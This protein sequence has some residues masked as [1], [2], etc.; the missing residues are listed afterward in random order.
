MMG[1]SSPLPRELT[2]RSLFKSNHQHIA[3]GASLPQLR[4]VA[5]VQQVEH[6]VC[7]GDALARCSPMLKLTAYLSRETGHF[8]RHLSLSSSARMLARPGGRRPGCP[9]RLPSQAASNTFSPAAMPGRLLPA[10][11]RQPLHIEHL[12]LAP[13][14]VFVHALLRTCIPLAPA[15]MM[16]ECT[17]EASRTALQSPCISSGASASSRP[18][19]RRASPRFG[20]IRSRAGKHGRVA[21]FRVHQNRHAGA[22]ADRDDM[23]S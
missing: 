13:L 11:N 21:G 17:L 9:P 15:V 6:P 23:E 8:Q 14:Q 3:Q 1:R 12:P 22:I 2:E 10:W 18:A 20:L 16:T 5:G 19:M 4:D 7:K